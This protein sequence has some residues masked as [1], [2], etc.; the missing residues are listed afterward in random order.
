MT[1]TVKT[2]TVALPMTTR[3]ARLRE[4]PRW[5]GV[6]GG[7][8]IGPFM[9]A[10]ALQIE[11]DPIHNT[12]AIILVFGACLL[13]G[14]ELL[15]HLFQAFLFF[16]CG[17]GVVPRHFCT[18]RVKFCSLESRHGASAFRLTRAVCPVPGTTPCLREGMTK[19]GRNEDYPLHLLPSVFRALRWATTFKAQT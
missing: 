4:M 2:T 17:G 15:N 13:Q 5:L 8:P 16:L 1:G 7:D 3:P 10:S 11:I 12:K 14:T 18:Q 6:E 9:V 19:R